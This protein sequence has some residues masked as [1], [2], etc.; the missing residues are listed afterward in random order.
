MTLTSQK[1]KEQ[2]LKEIKET[3]ISADLSLTDVE[4]QQAL[5]IAERMIEKQHKEI[6]QD[7]ELVIKDMINFFK[8]GLGGE[9]ISDESLRNYI[10]K[11]FTETQIELYQLEKT[12]YEVIDYY[13][14]K[15][16]EVNI[17]SKNCEAVSIEEA[18]VLLELE[19]RK[20]IKELETVYDKLDTEL[21]WIEET[22]KENNSVV[23]DQ[24][25]P[26]LVIANLGGVDNDTLTETDWFHTRYHQNGVQTGITK[27]N[28]YY[29]LKSYL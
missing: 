14:G 15:K 16:I 28:I 13:N 22:I 25:F 4:M 29:R 1:D 2:K 3:F 18:K 20:Q 17:I 21:I 26:Y 8:E 11:E 7:M 19:M 10:I 24:L 12:L 27:T 5:S 9:G 6:Q 23:G